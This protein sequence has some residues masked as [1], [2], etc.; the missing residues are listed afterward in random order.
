MA[1]QSRAWEKPTKQNTGVAK[2]PGHEHEA[3]TPYRDGGEN[4]TPSPVHPSDAAGLEMARSTSWGRSDGAPGANSGRMG[5]GG[6]S[7][8]N[9]GERAGPAA[10]DPMS[11]GNHPGTYDPVMDAV[12]RGGARAADAL[13]DWQTRRVDDTQAPAAGNLVKR[14]IDSGSP[15]GVVPASTGM[16]SSDAD[17]RRAAALQR[18]DGK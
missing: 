7:S 16:T 9:P 5:Y 17:A 1:I 10:I 12:L 14:G 18:T 13:D 2:A 15:G 6:P 11:P 8:V 4:K 3:E